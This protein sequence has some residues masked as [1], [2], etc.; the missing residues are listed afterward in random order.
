[1][2]HP[3]LLIITIGLGVAGC[4]PPPPPAALVAV[5]PPIVLDPVRQRECAALRSEIA[6]QQRIAEMSGIMATWLVEA[7]VRLSAANVITGLQ[8]RAAI[9]GCV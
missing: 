1:M 2:K 5:Q 7:S 9:E 4:A 8:T 6:K 3:A